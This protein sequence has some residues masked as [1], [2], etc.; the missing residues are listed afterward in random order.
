MTKGR[1]I[2]VFG[3]AGLRDVAKRS[4]MAE[5]AMRLADHVIFTA[6]DPRSERLE[7]ILAQ[8]V[9]GA[10][11]VGARDQH[12][13]AVIPDRGEAIMR[14]VELARTGDTVIVCGKG[15]ERSMCFEAIEYPWSDQETLAWS[16]ERRL[17]RTQRPMPY[18]LPTSQP[19]VAEVVS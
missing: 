7:D 19:P 15:H 14:A 12:R 17:G 16:L 9:E 6:E 1:I 4:L 18:R 8:M 5:T 13:F 3:S 11:G 10:R 2:A